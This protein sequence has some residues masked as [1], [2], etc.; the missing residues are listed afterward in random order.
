MRNY[1]FR[2]KDIKKIDK[3]LCKF[4]KVC[5]EC[6]K[7][8]LMIRFGKNKQM[9]DER[10]NQCIKCRYIKQKKY[11]CVCEYCKIEFKGYQGQRFCNKE[12]RNKWQSENNK[13]ENNSGWKRIL[14]PCENCH[15]L[16]PVKRYRVIERKHHFCSHKCY[17]LW[18]S[19][20]YKGVNNPRWNPNKTQEE[21][22]IGRNT[23]ENYQWR[24]EIYKRDCWT[25]QITGRKG[26]NLVAHHFYS[27]ADYP[28]LRTDVNNGITLTKE[29]HKIF[30]DTYGYKHN[31]KEQFDEFV[32]RYNNGEFKEILDK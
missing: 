27:Y 14:V 15:T 7:L 30:H 23:P 21:R 29:I 9:K 3:E 6:G 25:C 26:G 22:E 20:D 19:V 1:K 10:I 11:S 18:K 32:I 4:M 13:G 28:E 8:K 17:S 5:K 12:C 24:N 16:I 2:V 31:T